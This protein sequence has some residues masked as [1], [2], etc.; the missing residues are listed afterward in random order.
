M[1]FSYKKLINHNFTN[2]NNATYF[3]RVCCTKFSRNDKFVD[4]QTDSSDDKKSRTDDVSDAK[5]S[6]SG[7]C[8]LPND[9]NI[10]TIDTECLEN[11]G[12]GKDDR[13]PAGNQPDQGNGEQTID[14]SDT[15]IETNCSE[16][17]DKGE[18]EDFSQIT[19][20]DPEKNKLPND[21]SNTSNGS[22]CSDNGDNE[23]GD[24]VAGLGNDISRH[25]PIGYSENDGEGGDNDEAAGRGE[26]VAGTHLPTDEQEID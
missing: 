22:N 16:T 11:K 19:E 20:S 24:D 13:S 2:Q 25:T 18:S 6:D 12:K 8:K 17:D 14:K 3:T 4:A 23:A 1:Y 26:K 7:S 5:Q 9:N 21:N 15:T 10:I